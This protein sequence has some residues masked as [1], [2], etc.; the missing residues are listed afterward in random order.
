MFVTNSVGSG[1]GGEDGQLEASMAIYPGG[2]VAGDNCT[3]GPALGYAATANVTR[4]NND[5]SDGPGVLAV[6]LADQRLHYRAAF[7]RG[8]GHAL[9]RAFQQPALEGH[10]DVVGGSAALIFGRT[11]S[12]QVC[13]GGAAPRNFGVFARFLRAL[14]ENTAQEVKT[15]PRPARERAQ[16]PCTPHSSASADPH[17]RP[18]A[19]M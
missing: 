19:C 18:Q 17:R 10:H 6:V 2:V 16:G 14:Y 15:C 13:R 3:G 7:A 5:R 12:M 8:Q 4:V 9:R 11:H 1:S